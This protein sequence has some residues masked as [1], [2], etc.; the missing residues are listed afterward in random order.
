M[1]LRVERGGVFGFLG[2][3]GAGKTTT[4][5]LLL[6]FVRPTAGSATVLGYD[7]Q[8]ETESVRQRVGVL[9]DGFDLWTRSAG[10]EHL[11]FAI[12][13]KGGRESPDELLDRVGLSAAD[14]DRPVGRY[15]TGMYKRLG[16]AMAL[17]GDPDLL[18]L[19]FLVPVVVGYVRFERAG[20]D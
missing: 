13:S 16:M 10:Y 20:L 7:G 2:P 6:D 18:V 17:V 3:N 9:P 4:I 11:E 5:D 12:E 15:S 14:A 1:S 19:W 8:S